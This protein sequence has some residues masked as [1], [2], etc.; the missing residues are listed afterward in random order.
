MKNVRNFHLPLP[1]AIYE[2]LRGEARK[3]G[4]PATAVA[5]QALE[6]WLRQRRRD[7]LHEAIASYARREA[8]G[9][10]DLDAELE[11]AGLESLRDSEQ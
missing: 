7:E 10:S 8:G 9:P 1:E 6:A 2:G 5:R 11:E 4:R 3:R